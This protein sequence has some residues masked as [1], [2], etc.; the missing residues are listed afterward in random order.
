[1]KHVTHL[2]HDQRGSTLLGVLGYTFIS[3]GLLATILQ[4]GSNHRKI[5]TRQVNMEQAQYVA[6]GAVELGARYIEANL[7]ALG[8]S[9]TTSGTLG[10]G[11]FTYTITKSN[12]TTY[13]ITATGFVNNVRRRISLKRVYQPTFAQYALWS[14]ENGVIYFKSGEVFDGHVHA[15]DKMYFS[16]N[17][18]FHAECSSGASTYGGSI[19]AVTFDEGLTLN[20]E[21]GSMADIDFNSA[22]ST[23]LK[24][25]ATSS[26]SGLLLYG[27]ST[28]TF[29]GGTVYITNTR[30]GWT[31][32]AWTTTGDRII[33]VANATSGSSDVAGTAYLAGGTVTG[34]LT[35][36]TETDQYIRGHIDYTTDPVSNPSSTDALGLISRDDV[37]VDTTAPNNLRIDAAV[38]AAGTAGSDGSFG[39]VNYSSGSP[40]GSLNVYGGI[41]QDVRGAVGTFSGSSTVT[42]YSKNYSYD[43]RFIDDPP[44]YYPAVSG[45]LEYSNW[46][47]GN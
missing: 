9:Y 25:V 31:N 22:A 27:T 37:W 42:G 44:P 35:I 39:V 17:P 34:R 36:A 18:V 20:D 7:G 30:K 3:L 21:E 29:S 1:M 4:V 6:E 28:I 16:G 5:I 43:P 15:D 33:Y 19:S 14:H 8:S 11:T 32:H 10:A 41:V 12:S 26:S 47:E 13:S 45:K 24:S 23:S 40:R 46:Q 38:I 2:R